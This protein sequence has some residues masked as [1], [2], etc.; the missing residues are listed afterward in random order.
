MPG[1]GEK[2]SRRWLTPA[3]LPMIPDPSWS[4]DLDQVL[5][6][7]SRFIQEV[8]FLHRPSRTLILVDL[9]ENYG[10]NSTK[11]NWVLQFWW[12]YVFRMWNRPKP[13]PEYQLGWNDKAAAKE[14]LERILAWDFDRIIISH[15]DLIENGCPSSR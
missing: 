13:A 8:A 2:R 6:R 9:I 12:K 1:C 10:D 3:Y 11:A 4:T 5:I 14:S 15:G 7:G